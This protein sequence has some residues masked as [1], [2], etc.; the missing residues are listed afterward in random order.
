MANSNPCDTCEHFDPVLRGKTGPGGLRETAWGW[1]SKRSTYPAQE[2]PGQRFPDGVKRAEATKLAVPYI[3]R[4]G[5]V[6]LNCYD[7]D[8]RTRRPS[9]IELLKLVQDAL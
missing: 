6:V 9:K 2:G 4:R 7:Y 3:V 5:Q 1:C 8:L